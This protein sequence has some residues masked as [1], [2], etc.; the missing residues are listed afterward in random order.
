MKPRQ[1]AFLAL[2]LATVAV[3]GSQVLSYGLVYPAKAEHSKLPLLLALSGGAL[4]AIGAILL[5][6]LSLRRASLESERFIALLS[7][8]LSAYLLFVVIAGFGIPELFLQAKD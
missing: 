2:A 3:L 4:A 8:L 6:R 5:A 1:S 7:L